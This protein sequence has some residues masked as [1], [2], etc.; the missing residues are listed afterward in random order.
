MSRSQEFPDSQWSRLSEVGV[1]RL[2]QAPTIFDLVTP[3]GPSIPKIHNL[4]G[5]HRMQVTSSRQ[6]TH[7]GCQLARSSLV[8]L[9]VCGLHNFDMIALQSLH[10]REARGVQTCFPKR[11]LVIRPQSICQKSFWVAKYNFFHRDPARVSILNCVNKF[12]CNNRK[13]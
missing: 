2:R 10:T 12:Q 4:K 3:I 6:Q 1:K 9:P 11:L 7:H 5:R 8:P 13:S